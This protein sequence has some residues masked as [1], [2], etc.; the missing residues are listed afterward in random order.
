MEL[1]NALRYISSKEIT[2]NPI[3]WVMAVPGFIGMIIA[4]YGIISMLLQLEI[5]AA[6]IFAIIGYFSF[7][8]TAFCIWTK[9]V[10]SR[11]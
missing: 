7:I 4:I 5:I 1:M 9:S 2:L 6:I 3:R 11:T 8:W 10:P